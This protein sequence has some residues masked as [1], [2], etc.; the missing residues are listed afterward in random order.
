MYERKDPALFMQGLF[1][2]DGERMKKSC[3]LCGV[4][5][6]V[7]AF[8]QTEQWIYFYNGPA[9]NAD[10]ARSIIYGQDNNLYIGGISFGLSTDNDVIVLSIDTAG[11]EQWIYRYDGPDCGRDGANEIAMDNNG[12]IYAAGWSKG[13]TG[14]IDFI[15]IG[16]DSSGNEKWVYRYNGSA[17]Y[18]DNAFSVT[19]GL[20][21]N[22]YAAGFTFTFA[23]GVTD[24]IVVSL[25]PTDSVRWI[26]T[27]DGGGRPW[28]CA[29]SVIY[30]PDNRIY[31]AGYCGGINNDIDFVVVCLDTGGNE[32]WIYKHDGPGHDDDEAL[33]IVYGPD[34]N[35][36]AAGYSSGVSSDSDFVVISIDTA[37]GEKWVY[38][39]NGTGNDADMAHAIV[40]GDDNMLYAAG[41]TRD[42]STGNDYIVTSLMPSG[43]EQ[44]VYIYDGPGHYNDEALSID[45]GSD[46]NIYSAG[47]SFGPSTREDFTVVSLDD[48]GNE[49]GVYRYNG[50]RDLMDQANAIIYAPD[51]CLY[52]AGMCFNDTTVVDL[53]VISLDPVFGIHEKPPIKV[54]HNGMPATIFN[55]LLQFPT[56]KPYKI[57]DIT[58][59]QIHTLNP[60]PGIY[61]IEID[62]ALQHKVIKIK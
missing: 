49:L 60:A 16:V 20:D 30:G 42:M 59:R 11:N 50:S 8:A 24:L 3:I 34:H 5:M 47:Y 25:S 6:I 21:G 32:E 7:V 51:E 27:Y 56:D 45:Y 48:E 58:G 39:Y 33:S 38:R 2:L 9:N 23:A 4:F 37:G 40:Y 41:Y 43:S 13:I 44:W 22:I 14:D 26:Y 31:T 35:L 17:S 52:V 28:N 55:G 61:F 1:S 15:V 53:T 57:F 12:N 18:V 29:N 10:E 54:T 36:Y 46:G 19:T 62:G